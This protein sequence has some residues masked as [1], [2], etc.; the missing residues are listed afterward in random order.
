MDKKEMI[1]NAMKQYVENDC[2]D[3]KSFRLQHPK[4]YGLLPYYFDTVSNAVETLGWIPVNK[5]NGV[6]KVNLKDMLAYERICEIRE[7]YSLKKQAQ[8]YNVS[9]AAMNQIYKTLKK[10]VEP[11]EEELKN[12]VK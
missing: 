10:A 8:M 9:S 2:F 4:E 6:K 1:I 12:D 11:D 5:V 3:I 7:K